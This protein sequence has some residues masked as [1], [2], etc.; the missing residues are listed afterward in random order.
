MRVLAVFTL[1]LCSGCATWSGETQ[2]E[3]SA[4]LALHTADAVQTAQFQYEPGMQEDE[5]RWAIGARPSTRSVVVY[6]AAEALMH[7]AV[8]EYLEAH[9]AP[10][11]ARRLWQGVWLA[12]AGRDVYDNAQLMPI[13][14]AKRPAVEPRQQ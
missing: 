4:W 5:S 3:E 10:R 13:V 14:I 9:G 1:L 6:F 12:D 11:W 8:T 7:A 2:A